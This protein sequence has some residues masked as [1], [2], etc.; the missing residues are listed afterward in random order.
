MTDKATINKCLHVADAIMD[1]FSHVT[2]ISATIHFL[3]WL[4]LL[5]QVQY[6]NIIPIE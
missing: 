4:K 1:I 6:N 3:T 5:V 2:E